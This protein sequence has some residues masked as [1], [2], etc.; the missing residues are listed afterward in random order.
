MSLPSAL[1]AVDPHRRQHL[2]T[3]A[4]R[5]GD[6][7]L[8]QLGTAD[9]VGESRVV[10]HPLGDPGLPTQCAA[11]DHQGADPLARRVDRGGEP[12][13]SSSDDGQLVGG[14]IRLQLQA[15]PPREVAVGRLQEVVALREDDR[16]DRPSALLELL[17][18][19]EPLGV[20]VDVDP[21]EG[22]PVLGEELLGPL[23]VGAPRRPVHGDLGHPA[24]PPELDTGS[25]L[26]KC[27]PPAGHARAH[28]RRGTPAERSR[29]RRS[30]RA[31]FAARPPRLQSVVV[32]L[33]AVEGPSPEPCPGPPRSPF[34]GP[35]TGRAQASST[36]NG[37]VLLDSKRVGVREVAGAEPHRVSGPRPPV[38][39]RP[40]SRTLVR[41]CPSFH[42][43]HAMMPPS[44]GPAQRHRT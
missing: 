42:S 16:G 33:T 1:Q 27:A 21:A 8:G 2:H 43:P 14:P 5:L 22:N 28:L 19:A 13:R 30:A 35:G 26:P 7:P 32:P 3:V 40:P 38:D 17:D 10:V 6:E 41:T 12:R 9:A 11:V 4:P 20:L 18:E 29:R 36:V 23:A 25:G 39:R 34:R 31:G 15:Q 37:G 24:T 44:N